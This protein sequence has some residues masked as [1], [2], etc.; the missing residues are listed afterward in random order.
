MELM[1][2]RLMLREYRLS[3]FEAMFAL[4]TDPAVQQM[5]GRAALTI[6]FP[7]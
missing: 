7:S 4:D 3:D 2:V 1:T 5:R 6:R